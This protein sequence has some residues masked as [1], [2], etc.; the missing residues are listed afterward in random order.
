MESKFQSINFSNMSDQT[1]ELTQVVSGLP[2]GHLED[3]F[4]LE[5]VSPKL[6]TESL[7]PCLKSSPSDPS[8][9]R[10]VSYNQNIFETGFITDSEGQ[11]LER[12]E[13]S[14]R[15]ENIWHGKLKKIK[16]RIPII[17]YINDSRK[18]KKSTLGQLVCNIYYLNQSRQIKIKNCIYSYDEY[19]IYI[20]LQVNIPLNSAEK[21]YLS[22]MIT[23]TQ[24]Y[25]PLITQLTHL[26]KSSSDYQ[27]YLNKYQ[28]YLS[29]QLGVKND[30]S[31]SES[32]SDSDSDSESE[33]DNDKED[34]KDNYTENKK[35]EDDGI[36][37][38]S[39]EDDDMVLSENSSI[40]DLEDGNISLI[41]DFYLDI[42]DLSEY[43]NQKIIL[44]D[45][46]TQSIIQYN[47]YVSEL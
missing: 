20:N 7:K 8:L 23:D 12:A 38:E 43:K 19:Y 41:T 11:F 16:I 47:I 34:I 36:E 13:L 45:F 22:V 1:R 21:I 33:S 10:N 42:A 27:K 40:S 24:N 2:I 39:I 44:K 31:E 25:D 15:H 32:E 9:K 5:Q 17:K 29:T 37:N 30:D 18:N 26:L 6:E 4:L 28:I 35:D 14:L 3:Q 46:F